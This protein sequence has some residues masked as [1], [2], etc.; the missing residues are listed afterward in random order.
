MDLIPQIEFSL[1]Y[2]NLLMLLLGLVVILYFLSKKY[3]RRR[4]LRF[5]NF[6]SSRRSQAKS[7]SP[8]ASYP[9][10]ADHRRV[11]LV[12]LLSD[13][14]VIQEEYVARPTSYSP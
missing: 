4:V 10:S 5:G 7:C 1:K 9:R 12:A 14:V 13:V 11:L 8:Q 3:A 6:R 2:I